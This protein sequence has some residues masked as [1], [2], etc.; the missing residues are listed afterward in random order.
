MNQKKHTCGS[1]MNWHR[2]SDTLSGDK[3]EQWWHDDDTTQ[4]R[5]RRHNDAHSGDGVSDGVTV[6]GESGMERGSVAPRAEA[7]RHCEG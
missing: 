6:T 1:E 7:V 3:G 4:R 5:Q 2:Y